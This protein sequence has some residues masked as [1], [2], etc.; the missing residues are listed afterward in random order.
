MSAERLGGDTVYEVPEHV[1]PDLVQMFDFRTGLGSSPHDTIGKLHA[2]PRIFYTP[3]GHQNRGAS[4]GSWVVTKAEDIRY[5]LQHP[6]IFSSSAP[7]A[8]AMGESWKLIPLELDPP[9]HAKYRSVLNPVFSPNRLKQHD[10]K[11]REW[12]A[13]LI[14][15]LEGRTECD[16]VNAFAE[17][18]PVG[19]F[20][21]MMGLSRSEL[22]KFRNWVHLYIHDREQRGV[23]MGTIKQY[24]LDVIAERRSSRTTEDLVTLVI[25][26]Q[27]DGRPITDEEAVGVVFLLFVGGLDTVVSSLS[28]HFRYLAEHPEEQRKLRE[29]PSLIPDA[30]EELLRAFSVVTTSRT[31]TQDT[32]LCGVQLKKGDIVAASTILSTRDPDEFPDP[33]HVDLTRSPNRHNAFSFGIH[34]CL[35]SHLAR[36]ELVIALDEWL[37]RMPEFRIQEGAQIS[38]MGGGVLGLDCLPIIWD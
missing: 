33:T 35:G 28:F 19:I 38:A 3:V 22:G 11:I 26:M 20:L 24:L 37:K 2:G 27:I 14:G 17:A 15:R 9:D 36:R 25:D 4:T 6:E 16:F 32:E 5:V 18:Y 8:Q 1:Q 23:V 30:V 34:R 13:E 10:G 31:V 7:R 12:A 21:D 29:D